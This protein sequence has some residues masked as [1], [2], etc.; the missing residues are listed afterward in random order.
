MVKKSGKVSLIDDWNEFSAIGLCHF[1]IN[2]EI[3][4]INGP[5]FA[6]LK[7]NES[8]LNIDDLPGKNITE[9]I[10]EYKLLF[11]AVKKN[12]IIRDFELHVTF[13]DGTRKWLL[14]DCARGRGGKS[15]T[16][17]QVIFRDI[18]DYKK[19]Q[20]NLNKS[21]KYLSSIIDT[22]QDIVYRID[23]EGL[24]TFI[25]DSIRQYG[26]IPEEL[27][28]K[29]ITEIIHPDDREKAK[30]KIDERRSGERK[31]REFEI[32]LLTKNKQEVKF[33]FKESAIPAVPSFEISAEG[34]YETD[35]E[36]RKKYVGTQGVARDISIRKS[37]EIDKLMLEE[38]C[39][40]VLQTLLDGYYEIAING[41]V[42]FMNNALAEM[43]GYNS[44][45]IT[46]M[47]FND[48]VPA[49]SEK[50]HEKFTDW[51]INSGKI[52]L[53]KSWDIRTKSGR[54]KNFEGS[55]SQIKERNGNLIGLRGILRDITNKTKIEQDL[56]R[57]R[58]LEAIGILA[59]GIAHDYNNALTA[60]IGNISLAKMEV[61]NSNPD[62]IEI[63][64]D[65]ETASLK[66]KDLTQRLSGFAKGGRPVKKNISLIPIL[67]ESAEN[68]IYGYNGK[69]ELKQGDDI[70][71]V[72]AD[73]IQIGQVFDHIIKNAREAMPDGGIIFINI[74]N[75]LVDKEKSHHEISLQPGKYVMV[76]VKDNGCGIESEDI[77][78][79]F[80][81]YYTTKDMSSGMGLAISYAIIKR[82]RGYIDVRIIM[83]EGV[84][85]LIYFPAL[86]EKAV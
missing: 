21:E 57:A 30:Y 16:G 15:D 46:G 9:L 10:S 18:S 38:K 51:I 12:S 45:E 23:T 49:D 73:E 84:E 6:C 32:R 2:G 14:H 26:Y 33:E 62:L 53:I 34:L 37:I 43:L 66:A 41:T 79:I 61:G 50:K 42:L 58:K 76:S 4:S 35:E 48:F 44:D 11:D 24:V 68:V 20:M 55:V 8:V 71:D 3:L 28:G 52:N 54:I 64:N 78:K 69:Y 85:F 83:G 17:I 63:L 59:G 36:G 80:D 7:L 86:I 60:I 77:Y 70:W 81:P 67:K 31:T 72:D 22:I 25:S 19:I 5:A 74:E 13:K 29:S 47:N 65:A 39:S 82:H 1:G 56:L 40:T 75:V 27:I